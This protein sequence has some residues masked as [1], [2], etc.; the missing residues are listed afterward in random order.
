MTKRRSCNT[1][2]PVA[3]S[4]EW[5]NPFVDKGNDGGRHQA[6]SAEDRA[7]C[8]CSCRP[9]SKISPHAIELLAERLAAIEEKVA[10]L[11]QGAAVNEGDLAISGNIAAVDQREALFTVRATDE[12]TPQAHWQQHGVNRFIYTFP[13]GE[14]KSPECGGA[15]FTVSGVIHTSDAQGKFSDKNSV[16]IGALRFDGL[17]GTG[18]LIWPAPVDGILCYRVGS[19]LAGGELSGRILRADEILSRADGAAIAVGQAI[20]LCPA[21]G[22]ISSTALTAG[23]VAAHTVQVKQSLVAEGVSTG[24]IR[25]KSTAGIDIPIEIRAA[26]DGTSLGSLKVGILEA[27]GRILAPNALTGILLI[28]DSDGI[29][30]DKNIGFDVS[31]DG[32]II[33][34]SSGYCIVIKEGAVSVKKVGASDEVGDA[35][36]PRGRPRVILRF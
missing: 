11:D 34:K 20:S 9:Q 17:T 15:T 27:V 5:P 28:D 33:S 26:G 16:E 23:A 12:C 10:Y 22:E 24:V 25:Q 2:D 31:A 32:R 35:S 36:N 1:D 19:R 6:A 13:L 29:T 7:P 3:A 30:V 8:A 4:I 14:K 18:S 21:T